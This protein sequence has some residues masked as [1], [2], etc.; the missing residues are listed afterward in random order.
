MEKPDEPTAVI[1]MKRDFEQFLSGSRHNGSG[2]QFNLDQD[3]TE[4]LG[5]SYESSSLSRNSLLGTSSV[6]MLFF[7]HLF[8]DIDMLQFF[9]SEIC[10]RAIHF[11]SHIPPRNDKEMKIYH[12]VIL[13]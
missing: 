2:L 3:I 11:M 1:K 7:C 6:D 4:D 9:S 12:I 13:V 5:L 8:T 10:Q